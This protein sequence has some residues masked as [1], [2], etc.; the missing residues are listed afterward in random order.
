MLKRRLTSA[1]N[2]GQHASDVDPR[3]SRAIVLTAIYALSRAY[4][5]FLINEPGIFVLL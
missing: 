3:R 4:S 5:F 2:S 1:E